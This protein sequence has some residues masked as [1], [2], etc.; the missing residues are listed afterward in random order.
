MTDPYRI[1]AGALDSIRRQIAEAITNRHHELHPELAE[2]FGPAGWSHCLQDAEYHLSYLSAAVAA[3]TLVFF[4]EYVRWC[5]AMLGA[6]G[7][8]A[9]HLAENLRIMREVLKLN[10]PPEVHALALP[11]VDAGLAELGRVSAAPSSL[12]PEGS[13]PLT[14]LAHDYVSALLRAERH[15]AS[16]LIL[17]AA[18]AGT[19]IRDLYLQVFQPSQQEV[20]RLWQMNQISVAQEHYC[21]AA[22]QLIMSQLYPYIFSGQRKN[23]TLATACVAGDLHELGARV[24]SDLLEVEGWDTIYLGANVPT[25]SIIKLMQDRHIDVLALSATMTFH[26][27]VVER[28]I[29]EIRRSQVTQRVKILVG[30]YPFNLAPELW[31]RVDADAWAPDAAQ[32]IAVADRLVSSGPAR[33]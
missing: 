15:L 12:L 25:S 28:L 3:G 11:P 13:G 23:R 26:V 22:T 21:T 18:Q 19:P 30:G 6:R 10:L 1:A 4:T 8:A 32:A 9:E 31:K 2:R 5:K 14:Q 33:S 17:G 24:V 27:P 20:G 7:I 16:S 29:A